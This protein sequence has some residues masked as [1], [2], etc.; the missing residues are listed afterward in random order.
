MQFSIRLERG[1]NRKQCDKSGV[2]VS[3]TRQRNSKHYILVNLISIRDS[4]DIR[5]VTHVL[6]CKAMW[7]QKKREQSNIYIYHVYLLF[8][9]N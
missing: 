3:K 1:Y 4:K 6:Q 9:L 7:Y 2:K 8:L 5:I